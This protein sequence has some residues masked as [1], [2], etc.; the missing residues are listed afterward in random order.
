[1]N[2][3]SIT[4]P[5]NLAPTGIGSFAQSSICKDIREFEGDIA[6]LGAPFDMSIQGRSGCRLGPRGI[7]MAS[8]RFSYVPGGTYNAAKNCFFMIAISGKLRIVET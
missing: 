1:M 7:R 6:I 3:F 2:N 8:T 5:L 4:T